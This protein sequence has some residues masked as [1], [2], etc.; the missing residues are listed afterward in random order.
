MKSTTGSLICANVNFMTALALGNSPSAWIFIIGG[1]GSLV[2][3]AIIAV[4]DWRSP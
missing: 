2:A 3:A 4:W 1:F